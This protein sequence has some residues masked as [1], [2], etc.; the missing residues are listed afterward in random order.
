MNN[1]TIIGGGTAG[2]LSAIFIN[3]KRPDINLTLVESKSIGIV[4]VGEGTVPSIRRFIN[5]LGISE[6]DFMNK[7]NATKKIGIA[8]D[9]FM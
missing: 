7:T 3:K 8:F 2:W 4:G 9:T 1:I 5:R 6:S